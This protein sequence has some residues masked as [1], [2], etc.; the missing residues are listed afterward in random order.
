MFA[1]LKKF[2]W[3]HPSTTLIFAAIGL[4]LGFIQSD[5]LVETAT[6]ISDLFVNL[7]RLISL[8]MIFFSIVS[9]L[10]S[11]KN[12][13][14]VRSLGSK[15]IFYTGLTTVIAATVAMAC[16]L[17]L[18]PAGSMNSGDFLTSSGGLVPPREQGSYWSF[19]I[20]HIPSNMLEPFISNNVI[21]VLFL[22]ILFS[23]AILSLPE[24]QK[25][26]LND[27]F[28]ALFGMILKIAGIIMTLIPV[29]VCAFMILFVRDLNQGM[30]L[31]GLLM[32]ILCIVSANL[33]QALVILPAILLWHGINPLRLAKAMWPALTVAFFGKSSSAALPTVI[34]CAEERAGLNRSVSRFS[35][36]MC[37]TVNMNACAGFIIISVLF[38]SEM[39][40]VKFSGFDY[41]SWIFIGSIAAA[42]NAAVPMGCYFLA[43]SFLASQNIPL[44][45]MGAILPFYALLDMLETAINVW[46]D[47]C[48]TAI[49]SKSNDQKTSIDELRPNQASV[50]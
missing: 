19:L 41:L 20:K 50:N 38:V 2:N 5:I 7:L 17:F 32:Y 18:S 49:V 9:T 16:Y 44:T 8:P 36:P 39:H 40:G 25:K 15:V 28:E 33:I 26:T 23:A 47:S 43:S 30:N 48:V 22:S 27:L 1:S 24:T 21:G 45:I 34:R 35:F 42:G 46:S 37:A 14:E 29:A 6:I 3:N 31:S 12:F 13:Q 11:M 4:I 10:G